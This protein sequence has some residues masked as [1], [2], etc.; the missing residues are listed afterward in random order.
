MKNIV[1]D[2]ITAI[3]VFSILRYLDWFFNPN[4]VIISI[5]EWLI[6]VFVMLLITLFADLFIFKHL[7]NK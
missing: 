3:V 5:T 6:C 7:D 4:H 1:L 2:M